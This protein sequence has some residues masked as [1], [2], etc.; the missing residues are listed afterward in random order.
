MKTRDRKSI[1][2]VVVIALAAAVL[3]GC[4]T[5]E[6]LSQVGEDPKLTRVKNPTHRAGYRPVSMPMPAP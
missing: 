4:N 6:R 2:K 1:H 5:L 3:G